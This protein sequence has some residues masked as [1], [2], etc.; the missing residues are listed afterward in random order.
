MSKNLGT[1]Q[2]LKIMTVNG[3]EISAH[4]IANSFADYFD[5]KVN[6]IASSTKVDENVYNGTWKMEAECEMFMSSYNISEC[7][8]KIKLNN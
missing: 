4:K 5:K 1:R 6:T 8:N 7:I 3:V 2:I